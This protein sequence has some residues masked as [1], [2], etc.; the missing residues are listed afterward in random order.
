M[1]EDC[2][3]CR[4]STI[5]DSMAIV[6]GSV[7]EVRVTLHELE[8]VKPGRRVAPASPASTI[9][10]HALQNSVQVQPAS[11]TSIQVANDSVESKAAP[12]MVLQP[13]P[14]L[15][16]TPAARLATC[17]RCK[18]LFREEDGDLVRRIC[19]SGLFLVCDGCKPY[20]QHLIN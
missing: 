11:T 16:R 10:D 15:Q 13:S 3:A 4:M 5:L 2:I 8:F 6:H 9:A 14:P 18:Q 1:S 19:D 17:A 20:T 7:V 12:T